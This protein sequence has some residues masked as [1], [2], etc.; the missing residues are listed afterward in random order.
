MFGESLLEEVG[1]E[2]N[3]FPHEF[4]DVYVEDRSDMTLSIGDG[5][6]EKPSMG[7]VF[8]AGIRLIHN[9]I[10]Y[11]G[12]VDD[13]SLDDL[14]SMANTL[15]NR[16]GNNS[17][18]SNTTFLTMKMQGTLKGTSWSKWNK[19]DEAETYL[20]A[21]DEYARGKNPQVIQVSARITQTISKVEMLNSLGNYA[22][23]ERPRAH[24]SCS[25]YSTD[26]ENTEVG[27]SVNGKLG[28]L[29]LLEETSAEKTA[30][31]AVAMSISKLKAIVPASGEYPVILAPGP[32]GVIFHEA[33]GHSLEADFIRKHVSVMED[34][35]GQVI[36]NSKVTLIDSGIIPGEWGSNAF[37]DEGFPNQETILVKDGVLISYMSDYTEHLIG[38]FPHSSNGRRENYGCI[39]YPR[40]RN[41]Y[42]E[43]GHDQ[44]ED[45]LSSIEKGILV[46]M[47]GGGQVDQA[48][49]DFIFD[50][51]DAWLIE[52][53]KITFPLK[54]VSMIGNGL[55]TLKDIVGV[56]S[57]E[58]LK[59]SAGLCGK[60]NQLIPVGCGEP[61][62]MIS[63][64]F[65][66]GD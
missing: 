5:K 19:L 45:M 55:T 12:V 16:L 65:V 61:Y 57:K 1:K 25:I 8:G 53:G 15:G 47:L 37:D 6:L 46:N 3:K 51:I 40:M 23:E 48:T 11:F 9:G 39:P 66:G 43:P 35:I 27:Y 21:I 7:S 22:E 26:G 62:V 63:K 28:G 17:H 2:L 54:E 4:F 24:I 49:G 42:I 64:I 34:K 31:D 32:G 18:P 50:V 60:E 20:R 29:E 41:T 56:S 36:G 59:I 38:N 30:L 13:P 33:V 58:D 10:T 14:I 52:N 44:Y